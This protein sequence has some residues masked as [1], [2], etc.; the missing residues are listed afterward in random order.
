MN[1]GEP[2]WDLYRTFH[3]VV[4]EG[5]LSAAARSLGLTQPTV[6]R[7]L[8]TLEDRLGRRL[9]TRSQ[10]GLA[11]TE[12]AQQIVPYVEALAAT[13]AA[14]LRAVEAEAG[15]VSGAV[16]I[17]ASEVV[18]VERLPPI[19]AAVRR[20]YPALAL[21]LAVSNEVEDLLRR[22]ADIA[23]RMVA[24]VQEALVARK[25][26]VAKVGL[27]A[28]ADY[29]ARR[30]TPGSVDD[31]RRFDLIGFDRATPALRALL[32]GFPWLDP[33]RFALRSSSDLAQ[34]AALRAGFGIGA[35][36]AGI[37]ARE[38]K[39]VRVLPEAFSVELPA[40]VVMHEDLRSSPRC[41]AVFDVLV[42]HLSAELDAPDA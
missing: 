19:L 7:Q 21:E 26:G 23:V 38:P 17:T 32:A 29:L 18:G 15:E 16:R 20:R 6:A 41:R 3:A 34:L 24:P 22:D 40:W 42:D 30:G 27:F 12:A 37:A 14:L 11:P 2:A 1:H 13:G 39:L 5:S 35:C 8:D 28:R 31:L 36:Q 25:V 9:F 10:R 33:A 4:R